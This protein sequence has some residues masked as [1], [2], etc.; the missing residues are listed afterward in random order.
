MQAIPVLVPVLLQTKLHAPVFLTVLSTNCPLVYTFP[1]ASEVIPLPASPTPIL[2]ISSCL[3][4]STLTHKTLPAADSFAVKMLVQYSAPFFSEVT[5]VLSKLT[6][7]ET[8][9]VS[10][11]LSDASVAIVS[12]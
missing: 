7:P 2:Q 6:F 4:P 3:V 9:P 1:C 5:T 12:M 11:I 10:K 8:E